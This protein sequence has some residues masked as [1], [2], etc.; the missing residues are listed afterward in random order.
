MKASEVRKSEDGIWHLDLLGVSGE[1]ADDDRTLKT[2]GSHRLVVIHQDLIDLGFIEYVEGLPASGQ[3][4]PAL[5][6]NPTGWYGHNFG[7]RWGVYLREVAE[8]ETPVSPSHGFRHSFKTMCREA[9]VP[10]EIHDAITGHD[11]GSV[12]RQYGERHLLGSQLRFL[13]TL[14]SIARAAGLM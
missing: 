14:P 1:G 11:N 7:K 10:E 6:P 13:K 12:S 2:K 5:K 4:F 8:L 9:G 3:L